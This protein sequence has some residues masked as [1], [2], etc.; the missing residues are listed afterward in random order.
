MGARGSCYPKG[1][2]GSQE[3]FVLALFGV[4]WFGPIECGTFSSLFPVRV[5]QRE[6]KTSAFFCAFGNRRGFCR[7]GCKMDVAVVDNG[8]IGTHRENVGSKRELSVAPA[9]AGGEIDV[10]VE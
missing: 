5:L 10:F 8:F 2:A 7:V 6:G 9:A 4:D 1:K 3:V